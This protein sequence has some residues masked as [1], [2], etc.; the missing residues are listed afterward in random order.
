[1]P[2]R[3]FV[4]EMSPTL[5]EQPEDLKLP[6]LHASRLSFQTASLDNAQTR[7][8]SWRRSHLDAKECHIDFRHLVRV[9]SSPLLI[10]NSF[11]RAT[12]DRY[13]NLLPHMELV[14]ST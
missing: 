14:R 3:A 10:G 8:V 12:S 4:E 11:H 1:M 13:L 6:A 2:G 9:V 5:P 7:F